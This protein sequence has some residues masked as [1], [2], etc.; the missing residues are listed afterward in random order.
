MNQDIIYEILK[1]LH[2]CP[3]E[4]G[5]VI[6][7]K[8]ILLSRKIY[9]EMNKQIDKLEKPI[10]FDAGYNLFKIELT[11]IGTI[12]YWGDGKVEEISIENDVVAHVYPTYD[13]HTI[14]VFNYSRE[15]PF[16]MST[17][18][19]Q[20]HSI[21][22][23]TNL[24][25]MFENCCDLRSTGKKWETSNVTNMYSLFH[26][27]TKL[28]RIT[29]RNWNTSRVTNMRSMFSSCYKIRN[30]AGKYWDTANVTDM[31]HMFHACLKLNQNIGEYWDVSKVSDMQCMF[32]HC[33]ELNQPIG[34]NWNVSNVTNMEGM[35][36]CCSN[37]AQPIGRSWNISNVKNM[38]MMFSDCTKYLEFRNDPK[39]WI[40]ENIRTDSMYGDT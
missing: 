27:C 18:V 6:I 32:W 5:G 33:S 8:K 10:V 31:S 20:V 21:G 11:S 4:N 28:I 17:T 40:L 24:S 22:N 13:L 3:E 29:D 38:V 35:F 14:K 34:L 1:F 23:L 19:I 25:Q 2:L 12:I 26:N 36:G 39:Y 37:I 30:N 16:Y 15:S 7:A 9:R